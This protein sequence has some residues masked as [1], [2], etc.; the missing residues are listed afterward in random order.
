MASSLTKCDA[1]ART[2]A[3][4]RILAVS[5]PRIR[6]GLSLP[7]RNTSDLR[8]L[9]FGDSTM[10]KQTAH[11]SLLYRAGDKPAFFEVRR[12]GRCVWQSNGAPHT[13]G[14]A[15]SVD[16]PTNEAAGAAHHALVAAYAAA[17]FS[18]ARSGTYD[19]TTFDYEQLTAEVEK[20]AEAGYSAICEANDEAAIDSFAIVTDQDGITLS[21]SAADSTDCEN[22]DERFDPSCWS[23]EDSSMAGDVAYRM[24]LSK[25]RGIS[26]EWVD[27]RP[28]E[29]DAE[30][31]PTHGSAEGWS[32]RDGVYEAFVRAL[33]A[34]R[35][36]GAFGAQ[37]TFLLLVMITD[38][39][40]I[41]GMAKRLNPPA[42]ARRVTTYFGSDNHR[43]IHPP[44]W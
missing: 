27:G 4:A 8:Q 20:A 3:F 33:A 23:Y 26:F 21:F 42:L 12:C 7:G 17:G 11:W 44:H 5:P 15:S 31:P 9:Q 24:L 39:E 18:L 1:V 22:D 40:Q 19:P 36:N 41:E 13:W 37:D 14:E 43:I 32:H 38:S 2:I 6:V 29:D 34:L 28:P 16:H 30:D 25:A 10:T 35:A